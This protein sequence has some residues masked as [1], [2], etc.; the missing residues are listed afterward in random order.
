MSLKRRQVDRLREDATDQ[1]KSQTATKRVALDVQLER[2]DRRKR[3]ERLMSVA[4][5]FRSGHTDT[6]VNHDE[7]LGKAYLE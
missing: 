1:T 3:N 7:E 2:A 6:S 5:S 4:G